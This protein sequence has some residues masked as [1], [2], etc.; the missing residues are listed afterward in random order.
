[1]ACDLKI[2]YKR[3]G[4]TALSFSLVHIHIFIIIIIIIICSGTSQL[5]WVS[6]PLERPTRQETEASA[7]SCMSMLRR[8]AS[9]L[10]KSV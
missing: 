1:M 4:G 7:N 5:P 3:Q 8:G 2:D 6:S 9:S 10:V